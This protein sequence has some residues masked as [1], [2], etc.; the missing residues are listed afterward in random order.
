MK[1]SVHKKAIRLVEGGEVEVDGHSVRL[2]KYPCIVDPCFC[3][4][5]DSLCHIG[6]EIREPGHICR[7]VKGK[8]VIKRIHLAH[9]V[10]THFGSGAKRRD[11][12]ILVLLRI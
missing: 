1:Q 4:E 10:I 12:G 11:S 7:I 6:N 8:T 3:C 2:V 5:M 9:D